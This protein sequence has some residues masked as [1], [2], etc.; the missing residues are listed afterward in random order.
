MTDI[1]NFSDIL[2][3]L[4]LVPDDLKVP[5][6]R[7]ILEEREKDVESRKVLL[8]SDNLI[9]RFNDLKIFNRT[10]WE[11]GTSL[12]AMLLQYFLK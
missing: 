9:D 7:F 3:D 6:P 8:V 5:I 2:I 4:K 12:L 11:Q 10:L 1:S